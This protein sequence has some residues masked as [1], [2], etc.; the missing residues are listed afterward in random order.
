[1]IKRIPSVALICL[2]VLLHVSCKN[3]SQ[4][5]HTFSI[6]EAEKTGLPTAAPEEV[7]LS[8]ERLGRIRPAMQSFIDDEKIPGIL[9]MVARQGKVVHFETYGMMD[10]KAEK[11]MRHDTI[12]RIFSM[13]KPITS[14]A[15]MMLYEEGRLQLDDPVSMYIPEFENLK[16]YVGGDSENLQ[17]EPLEQAMIIRHLLTHTSGFTYEYNSVP[18]DD[19]SKKGKSDKGEDEAETVKEM[20]L[21]M[22]KNPLMAQPGSTWIYSLSTDVLGYVVEV[23]SGMSLDKFLAERFFQPLEMEDTGF[24][25]PEENIDRLGPTYGLTKSGDFEAHDEPAT[26]TF[27]KHPSFLSGGAGLVSTAADYIRFTQM[28]LNYGELDGKR[29]LSRETVELM[30][31]NHLPGDFSE[32]EPGNGFGLGFAVVTD[33][34]IS[35]TPYSEGTVHW[36]GAAGT[37]FR[38]DPQLELITMVWSQCPEGMGKNSLGFF[39]LAYE[40]IVEE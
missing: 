24:F 2:A 19:S 12:F 11:P 1:M 33:K 37:E 29:Y 18:K 35:G 16:V 28:I 32:W 26:S 39:D 38:I 30:M 14:A 8:S 4:P 31:M 27:A 20:I 21:R 34:A 23:V 40:A 3:D 25:V 9:T 6:A 5:K 36:G 17:V 15:I 22:S 13:T 7:G 10:V